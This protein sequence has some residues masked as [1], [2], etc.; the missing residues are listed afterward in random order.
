MYFDMVFRKFV[1]WCHSEGIQNNRNISYG[2]NN[3]RKQEKNNRAQTVTGGF[4]PVRGGPDYGQIKEG[5]L[6]EI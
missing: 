3:C 6:F 2:H 1:P 4:F 5:T